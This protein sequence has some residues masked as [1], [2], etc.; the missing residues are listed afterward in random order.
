MKIRCFKTIALLALCLM[1]CLCAVSCDMIT[2]FFGN[3]TEGT[4]TADTT[5][6]TQ[7]QTG[8]QTTEAPDSTQETDAPAETIGHGNALGDDDFM[9]AVWGD[10]IE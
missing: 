10:T 7:S 5:V 8:D 1:M 4:D 9:S 2:G 3:D 6:T